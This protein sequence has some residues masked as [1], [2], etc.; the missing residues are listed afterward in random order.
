[1]ATLPSAR[2]CGADEILMVVVTVDG[3]NLDETRDDRSP[4]AAALAHCLHAF[5]Y[6][7]ADTVERRD[8]LS[9]VRY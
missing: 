1:M 2:R 5:G 6:H 8:D 3:V 7:D 9:G 4:H